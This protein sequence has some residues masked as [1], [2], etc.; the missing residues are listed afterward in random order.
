[1]FI[2]DVVSCVSVPLTHVFNQ[3]LLNGY[4]PEQLKIAKVVP[5]FKAGNPNDMDNYRPIS[6][7]STFSKILEKIMANRLVEYMESNSVINMF[8]FG[9]RKAHNTTHPMVHLLNKISVGLNEK[10]FLQ[11]FFV[12]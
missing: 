4:V 7:L 1:M 2:K 3:S 6:L 12:T 10:K 5:I 9:F 8:Q 11:L